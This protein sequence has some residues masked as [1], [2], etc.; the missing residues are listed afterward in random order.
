M[1]KGKI[2]YEWRTVPSWRSHS[3][4]TTAVGAAPLSQMLHLS[5][6]YC[7]CPGTDTDSAGVSL[8]QTAL[9]ILSEYMKY[10]AE[11]CQ[12]A[13][14]HRTS[15]CGRNKSHQPERVQICF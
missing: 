5:H 3:Y 9:F 15:V 12:A 10:G 6:D 13:Q 14:S 1:E 2:A 8:S 7:T 11:P 4:S